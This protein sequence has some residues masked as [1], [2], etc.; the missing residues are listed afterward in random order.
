ML[1]THVFLK[2][3]T[4]SCTCCEIVATGFLSFDKPTPDSASIFFQALA[5]MTGFVTVV[6]DLLSIAFGRGGGPSMVDGWMTNA[7]YVLW[8]G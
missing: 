7:P 3:Q 5:G 1:M 8:P 4:F 2:K 6:A